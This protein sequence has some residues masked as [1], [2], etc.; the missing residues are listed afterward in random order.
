MFQRV[1]LKL[2]LYYLVRKVSLPDCLST[3]LT[4]DYFQGISNLSRLKNNFNSNFEHTLLTVF[5]EA[6]GSGAEK[7]SIQNQLKTMITDKYHIIE[8]KGVDS[9]TVINH[10]NYIFN[11][12][13]LNPV[14]VTEDNRRYIFPKVSDIRQNDRIISKQSRNVYWIIARYYGDISIVG[15]LMLLI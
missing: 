2:L 3:L 1:V 9:Y 8:R 6:S 15:I 10:G 7:H 4:V 14:D 11:T 12:N 5:E 13:G